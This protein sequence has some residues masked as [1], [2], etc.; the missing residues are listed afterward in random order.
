[1]LFNGDHSK[2]EM[3]LKDLIKHA[4]GGRNKFISGQALGPKPKFFIVGDEP[5]PKDYIVNGPFSGALT[6]VLVNTVMTLR[7]KYPGTNREDC[8]VTYFIKTTYR[9]GELTEKMVVDD[10][11]PA[12]QLEYHLSGCD[13]IV[14]VG[15]M[16]SHFAGNIANRPVA[17][18][19]YRPSM[20][21]RIKHAYDVVR[22]K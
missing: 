17:L 9:A 18:K 16:A 8:Y 10:W 2:Y 12:L 6:D 21:A 3:K 7:G 5:N 15:R 20:M 22:G 13:L 14:C 1:M 19:D 4:C 11:L